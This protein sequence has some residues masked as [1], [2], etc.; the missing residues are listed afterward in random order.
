MSA[1]APTVFQPIPTLRVAALVGLP[2]L[3][4][5]GLAVA[6]LEHP[7][8]YEVLRWFGPLAVIGGSFAA[9]AAVLVPLA[10]RDSAEAR[11]RRTGISTRG[12][13]TA[14]DGTGVRINRAPMLQLTLHVE[15]DHGPREVV[16]QVLVPIHEAYR[17][18]PGCT[19]PLRVDPEHP[20]HVAVDLAER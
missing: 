11:I 14:V 3:L 9:S 6:A 13:V 20:D 8:L 15:D 18:R 7:A 17:Y 12:V 10:R 16:T 19:L 1:A 2:A 5:V 4:V